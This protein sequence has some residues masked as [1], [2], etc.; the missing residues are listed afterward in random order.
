MVHL[1]KTLIAKYKEKR[2]EYLNKSTLR[3]VI[4]F[5]G[6]IIVFIGGVIL[7]GIIINLREIPL[8]N[9][10]KLKGLTNLENPNIIIERKNYQLHLYQDTVLVKSYRASFGRNLS[11]PKMSYKD[12]ATP[13]GEYSVCDID[14]LHKYHKFI[15]I[16]YPNLNDA[17]V[18]LRKGAITQNEFDNLKIEYNNDE[19]LS[20]ET[21]LG[22]NLGIH[23]IGE[24]NVF[25]KNLPFVFNWTN[26][27]V[28]VSNEDI[29]ELMSVIKKGSKVVIH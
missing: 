2:K 18:G 15:Y 26:G 14:S 7:Y 21:T 16:N 13:V 9:A 11:N 4:I 25:F 23:G 17:M 20:T 1:V 5:S 8:A 12:N 6:G 24:Y 27:S 19:C 22:N 10:I 3:N 28:A 29:D